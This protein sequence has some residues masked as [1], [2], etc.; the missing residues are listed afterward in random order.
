MKN[1]AG[2]SWDALSEDTR[3]RVFTGVRESIEKHGGKML[4][5]YHMDWSNEEQEYSKD[6]D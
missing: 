3:T 1:I 5:A 2:E 4:I 6:P